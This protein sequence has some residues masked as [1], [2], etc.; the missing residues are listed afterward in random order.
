MMGRDNLAKTETKEQKRERK[1]KIRE[2]QVARCINVGKSQS[3]CK[4]A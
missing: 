4:I 1:P 2:F 3:I